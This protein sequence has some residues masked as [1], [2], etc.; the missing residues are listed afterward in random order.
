MWVVFNEGW[1]QYDTGR[2]TEH[3]K[4]LD[5]TRLVSNASGWTDRKVGDIIDF[6]S[7]PG[8]ASPTPEAHRAAVLGEFGGLGLKIDGHTWE[9]RTWGYQGMSD[10]DQ[11]TRRY[12]RLMQGVWGLVES[13]GL[14]AAVYTQT[15]DVETECNGFLTYDREIVKPQAEKI[16]A[17]NRGEIARIEIDEVVPTSRKEGVEWRFTT[18]APDPRWTGP[19]FDDSAWKRGP[20]GFGTRGTPGSVVRTEWATSDIWLRRTFEL[21]E[22]EL[23]KGGGGERG[24]GDLVFFVHHD[25]DV[26]IY[27]NGVLAAR[28]S[29]FLTEYEELP[30]SKEGRA[31]LRKGKNVLAVHCRQTQGGQYV[32]LGI[33][34]VRAVPPE[35][36]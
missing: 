30:L 13:P 19:D 35:K 7:Y 18:T 5:P 15:T 31:A 10:R 33:A 9:E 24:A 11:L 32:D 8:P 17:A 21:P 29:G 28:S 1:G 14:S 34:R 23:G 2:L 16:A 22:R 12:E 36:R 26:E 20:G 3:V 27:L 25:E 4:E 6:H